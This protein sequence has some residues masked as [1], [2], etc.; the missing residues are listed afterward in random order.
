MLT[1]YNKREHEDCI[2][3]ESNFNIVKMEDGTRFG[4][5]A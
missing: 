2:S 5:I 3:K 4:H 1:Q